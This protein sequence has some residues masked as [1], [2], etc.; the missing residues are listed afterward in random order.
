VI[1]E[2]YIDKVYTDQTAEVLGF[3]A[4]E[5]HH[6]P[7]PQSEQQRFTDAVAAGDYQGHQ[8][9]RFNIRFIGLNNADPNNPIAGLDADGNPVDQGLHPLFGDVRVRQALAYGM[10]FDA[11][12]EGVFFGFGLPSATHSRPDNWVDTSD[13]EPYPFDQAAA[14]SLL[15][16]AGWT[17]EDGDGIRECHGCLYATEVDASFEGSPL[18]FELLTNAGNVSQEALGNVLSD[19]WGEIGFDVTFS[20]IDFNVLVETFTGQDFDAVMIFWGFGFPFD[21]DGIRVTFGPENDDPEV[22]GFNAV[23]YNNPRVTEILDTAIDLPGCD[24]AARAE[25]YHEA[26]EI[27]RDEV[28]WLWVGGATTL[29]VAQPYVQNWQPRDTASLQGLWNVENWIVQP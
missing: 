13:I 22:G 20:P 1:P 19:Q 11:I 15:D 21:N 12:N 9:T 2:G 7:V 29:S 5:I 17:D 14:G 27:L 25:L 10:D 23:S 24:Q 6:L 26:Y 18:A 16:E 28:P 3:E 4:G 8:S